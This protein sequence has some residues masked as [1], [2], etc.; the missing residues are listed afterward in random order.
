[1]LRF[2]LMSLMLLGLPLLAFQTAKIQKARTLF[3]NGQHAQALELYN[4]VLAG[5]PDHIEALVGRI[6]ALGAMNKLD[7][8]ASMRNTK[9]SSS[10]DQALVEAQVY[11][12]EKNMP[13]AVKTLNQHLANHPDSFMG[14]YLL[15]SLYGNTTKGKELAKQ[16]LTKAIQLNAD[17]PESYFA[18][19]NIY[20][21]ESNSNK[22]REYWNQYLAKTPKEGKRF[23]YVSSTLSRMGGY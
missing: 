21:K 7:E 13:M 15:G 12:W 19:G 8:L 22:T 20:F 16:H 23:E 5:H 14:H 4:E 18:I 1:M 2:I 9:R 6:D 10:S 3:Y 17:F 11:L